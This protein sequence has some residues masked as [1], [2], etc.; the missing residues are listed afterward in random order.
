MD[1]VKFGKDRKVREVNITYKVMI[2]DEPGW[3]HNVV[4]RPATQCI[5]LFEIENTT[6]AENMEEIRI[7]AEQI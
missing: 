2:D 7:L 3:R 5:K 4:I 6:Y 1:S